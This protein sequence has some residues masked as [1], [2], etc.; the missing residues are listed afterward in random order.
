M[1]WGDILSK[2]MIKCNCS[3]PLET[4]H[5]HTCMKSGGKHGTHVSWWCSAETGFR[6]ESVCC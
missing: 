2:P 1:K 5:Y 6:P 4:A 3:Q